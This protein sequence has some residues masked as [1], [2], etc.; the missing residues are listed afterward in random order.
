MKYSLK[1]KVSILSAAVIILISSTAHLPFYICTQPQHRKEIIAR[2]TALNASLSKAVAEGLATENIDL[3]KRAATLVEAEDVIFVQV[4]SSLWEAVDAYPFNRLKEL[5]DADAVKRFK[6]SDKPFHKKGDAGYDFYNP[7]LYKPLEHAPAFHIGFVR[8]VLSSYAMEKK[9]RQLII[10]NISAAA[11]IT[12][13]A[14]IA[15]NILSGRLVVKPLL[16]LHKSV[17]MFKSGILP[18]QPKVYPNDEIGELTYEFNQMAETIQKNI[19]ELKET[20]KIIS[21]S[22]QDWEETFDTIADMITVHDKDFNVIRANKAAQK[23]LGL[24]FLERESSDVKCFKYYHGLEKPPDGCASC[25]CLIT[26]K[27][28]SFEIFEP[29]LKMF[30]EINAYPRLDANSEIA[31]VIH[32]VRDITEQR[33]LQ[34]HLRHSQ[35]LESVGT[36]AGGIAHDFNN[37]LTA[38]I[39]YGHILKMKA[40]EGDPSKAYIEQI[41]ASA[42]RAANLTQSLLS[43]S[44]KQ[45]GNPEPVKLKEIIE[46]VG[47]IIL[48]VIGENV[49]LK[50]ELAGEDLS[51]MADSGQMEQVLVNLCTNARDA[52]PEGGVLAIKMKRVSGD[53]IHKTIGT[54]AEGISPEMLGDKGYAEISIIDTGTGMDEKDKRAHI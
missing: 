10:A 20:E 5:P 52:M 7:I 29:H 31:G 22:T 24:P 44:R 50:T 53:K 49:E 45:T 43:F 18:E 34:E 6:D 38:I 39:G 3:I 26:G 16:N 42:E 12:F 14:F 41:L 36:L 1:T 46:K 48:R 17:T 47:M 25:Q 21:Q 33:K 2:G 32:V 9:L 11:A 8:L 37:I 13:F 15:I 40:K 28:A 27:A 4:Y 51:V 54:E 19:V 23:I 30:L 35:R